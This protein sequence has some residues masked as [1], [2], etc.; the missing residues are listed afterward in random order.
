MPKQ[1]EL[2]QIPY[3]AKLPKGQRNALVLNVVRNLTYEKT[4]SELGCT[5]GTVRSRISR[6]RATLQNLVLAN[7]PIPS[8][9]ALK[10][11][12]KEDIVFGANPGSEV[13][14]GL[15]IL[16]RMANGALKDMPELSR[17]ISRGLIR[18]L[19]VRS[20]ELEAV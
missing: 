19:S 15:A 17:R 14:T 9:T 13:V 12:H 6:A 5:I 2:K 20:K 18:P 10:D 1:L 4:A 7:E 8:I 11:W 3:I 16:E